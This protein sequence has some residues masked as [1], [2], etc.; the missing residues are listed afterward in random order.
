MQRQRRSSPS[1]S[2]ASIRSLACSENC[3]MSQHS[4]RLAADDKQVFTEACLRYVRTFLVYVVLKAG[5]PT[6]CAGGGLCGLASAFA[7][8]DDPELE[9]ATGGERPGGGGGAIDLRVAHFASVEP[10][11]SVS[12]GGPG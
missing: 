7:L 10:H 11:T 3:S 6:Q 8:S 4:E 1:R 9:R 2:A 5:I 12:P